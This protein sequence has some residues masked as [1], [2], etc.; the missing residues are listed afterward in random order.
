MS[1]PHS[2]SQRLA[3]ILL[4]LLGVSLFS[5]AV[6]SLQKVGWQDLVSRF[7]VHMPT[8]AP[9][10]EY[11]TQRV[12]QEESAVIDVVD[13]TSP[14]V[15]SV[16]EKQVSFDWWRGPVLSESSI[17]TGFAVDKDLIV[18]NR[19]VVADTSAEYTV[20]DKD[21][22]RYSTVKI[23]RDSLNDLAIIRIE[24]GNF[25]GLDLGD[26]DSIKVGQTVVAIGNALGRF[27]N[28]VTKGVISGIGRGI[29]ASS[30]LGQYQRLEDVFQTDAALN[31]GNSGGPL[32]NLAG[33]VIGVNVAVG[34]GTENIGF[35]IP[36]KYVRELMDNFRQNKKIS[37]PYLGVSY[38]AVSS[39][40][41]EQ[42]GLAAGA[43]VRE[44][45]PGTAAK[46]AGIRKGDII[47][48][49]DGVQV[50]EANTLGKLILKH[51][52]GDK[53]GLK[54]WRNGKNLE[55]TAILAEAP[56]E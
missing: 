40:L 49:V 39:E 56:T 42:R 35:A 1:N 6:D 9:S 27:S 50:D 32:L 19:H 22:K 45:L 36:S 12:V 10:A 51:K 16:L 11:V 31:P 4:L 20:V 43:Y 8:P 23:Y 2:V 41:A 15:V 38:V 28:T 21:G 13:K 18:T 55:L 54:I 14:S 34:E 29:T 5:V 44:V 26:S 33:Q 37:R 30:G 47:T 25:A 48:H 46:S 52:V 7:Q 17:G 3:I 53:V 24:G